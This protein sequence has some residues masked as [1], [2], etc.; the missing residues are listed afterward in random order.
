M[1]GA[2]GVTIMWVNGGRTRLVGV[3]LLCGLGLALAS[4]VTRATTA[5]PRV[6][7]ITAERFTFTPAEVTV[8]PGTE[9]EFVLT[10]E[11]TLHGFRILGQSVD[12]SIPKRGRGDATVRFTPPAEG[13]YTFE[14][15]RMCGAGHSFM[16]GTIRVVAPR[17]GQ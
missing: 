15:S 4:A 13:R 2:A 9:I 7:R 11:D 6:V 17:V 8:A 16:R 3:V 14:C 5:Q 10:S 12:V 1:R